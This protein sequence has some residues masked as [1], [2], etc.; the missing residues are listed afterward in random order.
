M[1]TP[2]PRIT[3]LAD[4][5]AIEAA[6]IERWMPFDHVFDALADVSRRHP[7]RTALTALAHA[8]DGQPR[9]WTYAQLIDAVVRAA[10]VVAERAVG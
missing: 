7:T 5:R 6:G 4:L 9:R 8:E 1:T 3:N 10:R 2:V